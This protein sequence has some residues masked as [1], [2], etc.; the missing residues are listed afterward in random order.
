MEKDLIA[1]SA[2]MAEIFDALDV[3]VFVTDKNCKIVAINE[4]FGNV[5]TIAREELVGLPVQ[6]MLDKGYIS[7]SVCQKVAKDRRPTTCILRYKNI[8]REVIVTGKPVF[9]DKGELNYIVCTLK[10]WDLLTELYKELHKIKKQSEHYRAQLHNIAIQQM[11][12]AE[13]IAKDEKTKKMLQLATRIAKGDSAVLILGESGV[14]K[15]MLAKFIHRYSPRYSEQGSFVHVNCGAIPESL[16][17]AEF[18]GYSPGAFTG[19]NKNGKPGLLEIADKG[20]LFLDEIAELPLFMQ[21]KLLKVLQVRSITRVGDT[22]EKNVDVKIIAATNKDL[23][24]LVDTGQFRED[25]YYRLNVFQVNIPSLR[26]RRDDIPPLISHFLIKFNE[27]YKQNK[28][29][30]PEVVDAFMSYSWPGNVRELMHTI[31]R[32]V[33]LCPEDI[34]DISH[35]PES[36]SE[37]LLV[38]EAV[39][40]SST[41]SLK[42]II[43]R[44]E[45]A[46]ILNAITK[47]E[48]LQDTAS[49]LGLDLSTLTRKKQK[50]GIFKKGAAMHQK[51]AEAHIDES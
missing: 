47:T 26:Q 24:K 50:Y 14:G 12:D 45:K 43:E 33:V 25:L 30:K 6:Y 41:L 51:D 49:Q 8:D 39:K 9:D 32:L 38:T 3:G 46:V 34:I 37:N 27:K 4:F 31:E 20:T 28:T 10:D 44:V 17:E 21:A 36:F 16:F 2:D 23:K 19:A 13:Y 29:I 1:D 5:T 48:R 7:E 15:D 22:R 42:S 40:L 11:E 18:F 35:L